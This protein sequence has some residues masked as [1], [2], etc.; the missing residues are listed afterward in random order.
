MFHSF[1]PS[2]MFGECIGVW[3]INEWM[4][5]G[6][7]K[8]QLVELGPGKGTLTSDILRTIARVSPEALKGMS[9]H[10][11]EVSSKMRQLQKTTL[12]GQ[13]S[14]GSVTEFGPHVSWYP[15]LR[16]VP[17]QFSFFLAHE[18]FD[19]LPVNKFCKTGEGW[20]EVLVD[21]D[22]EVEGS[23]LRYVIARNSTP[24]CV[25]LDQPGVADLMVDRDKVELCSQGGTLIREIS[26]RVVEQG[27]IGLVADYGHTGDRGDTFRAFRKHKQVD[28][29][30]LPGT[31]DLTADVDFGFLKSQVSPD[32]TWY[33]PI[34]QG[35]F[36]HSCGISTRCQQLLHTNKDMYIHKNILES[37]DTLTNPDKMGERFK[38]VSLFPA[39]MVH[40][41]E[42][43]PPV[44]FTN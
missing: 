4:K 34:S 10:L 11:V 31:A 5:M 41:H 30:D 32:C 16:E 39:T 24:S 20:R 42:K 15:S 13:G 37:F 38:F 8:F 28:P 29:L 1:F 25:L 40:I 43:Y 14:D 9:V 23:K 18:F 36:L 3:F 19:A 22:N 35:T 44:G 2:Q 21:I 27:G 7:P 26:Q 17:K 6:E 33:G 12:C